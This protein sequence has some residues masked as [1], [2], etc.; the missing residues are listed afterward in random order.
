[1]VNFDG[2]YEFCEV[3]EL[4]YKIKLDLLELRPIYHA[5]TLTPGLTGW[6][7]NKGPR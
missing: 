4:H 6:A 1:M 3:Q 2:V 5:H 7:T